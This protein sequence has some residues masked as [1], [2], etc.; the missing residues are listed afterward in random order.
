MSS[1]F[2]DWPIYAGALGVLLGFLF[3]LIYLYRRIRRLVG[4]LGDALGDPLTADTLQSASVNV[5]P[6]PGTMMLVG[7][8]LVGIAGFRRKYKK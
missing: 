4:P 5:I 6:E 2:Q 1:L 3:V 7:T 8:G